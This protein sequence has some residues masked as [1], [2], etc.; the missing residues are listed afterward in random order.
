MSKKKFTDEKLRKLVFLIH[1]RYFYEG[2]VTSDKARNYQDYIDIQCQTYRKTKKR[3]DWQEVK[4]LTKEYEDFLA[5]EV[6]I[7]RKLLLF[8][9]LKRDQKER[10]SMYLLLVKKYHLERWV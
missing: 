7:K 4:R 9:L 3:K 8:G 10:Q 5:N 2:V 1:A 6:D